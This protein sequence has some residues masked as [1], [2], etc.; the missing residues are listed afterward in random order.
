V[1]PPPGPPPGVGDD[2]AD[3]D[4]MPPVPPP[5][6]PGAAPLAPPPRGPPS[7]FAAVGGTI[8][9]YAA[10]PAGVPPNLSYRVAPVLPYRP[11]LRAVSAAPPIR[12]PPPAAAPD[13]R[14]AA[15]FTKA[16]AP[17]V[18]KVLPAQHNP[19]LKALVPASVRI[20][21][22]RQGAPPMK[23]PRVM[24]AP[25]TSRPATNVSAPAP[26]DETY[27]NFLDDV[28]DLGAFE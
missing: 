13:R 9:A 4:D 17:T 25:G 19:A 23:R 14:S 26:D 12:P 1:P 5:P 24:D 15:A 8:P 3:E 2:G 20:Q 18:T 27:L 16:A 10:A 21:R 28:R 7:G 11:Q 6:P 22:E